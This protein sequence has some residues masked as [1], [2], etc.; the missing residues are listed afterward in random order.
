MGIEEGEGDVEGK[1]EKVR[2]KRTTSIR[3]SEN[4]EERDR[5][6]TLFPAVFECKWREY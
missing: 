1:E 6:L 4:E 3:E 2:V 5:G